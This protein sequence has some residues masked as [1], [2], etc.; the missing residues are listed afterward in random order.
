M[1]RIVGFCKRHADTTAALILFLITLLFFLPGLTY[2]PVPLDNTAYVGKEYLL[3]PTWQN[4]IYHLKT[5]V[6]G[7][8]SPLVMHSLMLDYWLWGQELLQIGGRLHNIILHGISTVLFYLLL[9]QLKLVRFSPVHP[10]KLSI[11][12]A[13]L[14]ALCFALHAQRVE[15]VIWL[16]ERKDVQVVLL[17]LLSTICFIRSYRK[18]RLPVAGALLYGLSFAAK[19]MIITL[20][21]VLLL[22]IWV[23]T[24][25]FDWKK[26][27]KMLWLYLAA[28]GIYFI[29][30]TMQLSTFASDSASG[31]FSLERWEIVA[32]NYANYFFRTLLPLGVRPLYPLFK[33]DWVT[34]TLVAVFWSMTLA[35]VILAF[36]KWRYRQIF[37]AFFTPLLLAFLGVVLPVAGFQSIGNAE[38]ADRYSYYP[39]LFVWIGVAV[40][41]EFLAPRRTIW[42]F[43][44]WA[45][46]AL[47]AV[48]GFC[49]LQ[50][51][52]TKESFIN[53]SLGDG[54]HAHSAT[55]RMAAWH[56]FEQKDFDVAQAF[57]GQALR[58]ATEFSRSED[59]L[60]YR[61]L[62]GAVLLSYGDPAGLNELDKVLCTPEWG[63][64]QFSA[65]GFS[66]SIMLLTANAHLQRKTD[67]DTGF[68]AQIFLVLGDLSMNSDPAR[69]LNYKAISAMLMKDYSQAEKLTLQALKYAPDDSNLLNNLRSI[70]EKIKN[71]PAE[72]TSN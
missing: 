61:A 64:F 59:E 26:S 23:S 6:L 29:L 65:R 41:Y 36:I 1:E 30:N 56:S 10:F 18:N 45:Y 70:R 20:P 53:V 62:N 3:Y 68:A 49:Y 14:G 27:L 9:R 67:A 32:S 47:I 37:A 16:V 50:T 42:Q 35:T 46:A 15:S 63:R 31:L 12:A 58:N 39:S 38:F 19:P 7:L 34:F 52:Q 33:R 11:P 4:I 8:Y 13:I 43:I 69:D 54:K 72:A 60:F 57:A 40:S 24:E 25:R 2:D 51:W 66:E 48:Q 21:G 44:F 55:L 71:P 22:G 17:G 5:P 28:G